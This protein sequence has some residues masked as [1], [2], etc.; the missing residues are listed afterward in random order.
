MDRVFAMCSDW[1]GSGRLKSARFENE[2]AIGMSF[3]SGIEREFKRAHLGMATG[4]NKMRRPSDSYP[5]K[6]SGL[7]PKLAI[8]GKTTGRLLCGTP[9]HWASVEPY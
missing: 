5:R 2:P 6:P 7:T 4:R 9:N 1:S 3:G 8:F